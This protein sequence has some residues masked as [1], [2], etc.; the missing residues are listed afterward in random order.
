MHPIDRALS[1]LSSL[2]DLARRQTLLRRLDP[3]AKVLV[4]V[5]FLVTLA[6]FGRYEIT[7]PLPLSLFLTVGVALGEIPWT[8]LLRRLLLASPFALL[9]GVWNPLLEPEPM[10]QCGPLVLSAGWV[11][12]VSIIE[13]FVFAVSAVLVLVATTGFDAVAAALGKLGVPRPLTTQLLLLYR[14]SFLLGT[15]ASRM[16]QAHALRVPDHPRP[17]LRTLRALLGQL[18]LRALARAERVH[19]AMLCRGFDGE[20]RTEGRWRFGLGNLAFVL[21]CFGFFALVRGVH[22]PRWLVTVAGGGA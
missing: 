5:G 11:S 12:F 9:V 4:V 2:D 21:G 17:T 13:R 20:L 19:V 1:H 14:Y 7:A 15:E 3:R 6:S 8:V 18:L 16:L 10:H 22:M